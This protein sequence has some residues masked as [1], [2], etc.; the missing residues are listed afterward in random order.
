MAALLKVALTV[1]AVR[2]AAEVLLGAK[3]FEVVPAHES[4]P[5]SSPPGGSHMEP[6]LP[7]TGEYLENVPPS[8]PAPPPPPPNRKMEKS[9]L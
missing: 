2:V 9:S 6:S 7:I 5:L 8:S 4:G 1:L 3:K